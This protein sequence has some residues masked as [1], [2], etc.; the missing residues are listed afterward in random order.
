MTRIAGC[1]ADD[2][3]LDP[4]CGA[5]TIPIEARL[6]GNTSQVS[7]ADLSFSAVRCAAQNWQAAVH[8]ELAPF[9]RAGVGN[10]V[11]N[12]P[13]RRRIVSKIISNPPWG[14]QLHANSVHKLYDSL[15]QTALHIGRQDMVCVF[16]TDRVQELLEAMGRL[17]SFELLWVRQI[18]LF[19]S[20]PAGT[21]PHLAPRSRPRQAD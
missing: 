3:I 14:K 10:H 1:G 20:Y 2:V 19:G 13:L 16:L 18:S 15:L 8:G 4:M 17:S 7:G 9:F 11:G 21:Q 6:S 5:G 12:Y